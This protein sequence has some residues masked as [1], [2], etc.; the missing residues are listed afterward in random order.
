MIIGN[1]TTNPGELRTSI[2]LQNRTLTANTG[3]FASPAWADIATVW[4]KWVNLHGSEAWQAQSIQAIGSATVLIRYRSGI[5]E[6]CAVLKGD[7]RYEI[8]SIDNVRERGEYLELKVRR[9]APG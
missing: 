7:V 4:A 2:T 3:G 6:T 5:D 1:Q 9:M 8:L